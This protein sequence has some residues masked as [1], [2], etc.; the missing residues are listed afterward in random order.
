MPP[1]AS[2]I[3]I[4]APKKMCPKIS[5]SFSPEINFK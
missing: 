2:K 5:N 1:V 4:G 3:P